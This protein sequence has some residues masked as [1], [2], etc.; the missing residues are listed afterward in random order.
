MQSILSDGLPIRIEPD[1]NVKDT[2]IMRRGGWSSIR[3][4]PDWNV[5]SI[6]SMTTNEEPAIRIEPD[7]NVKKNTLNR[8]FVGK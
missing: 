8:A 3:I 1:W 7:W 6:S 5:K 2:Y 4:E